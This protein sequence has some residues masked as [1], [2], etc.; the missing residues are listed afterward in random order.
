MKITTILG[1]AYAILVC[2]PEGSL[3]FSP[4]NSAAIPR[5]RHSHSLLS[6]QLPLA[7]TADD[8]EHAAQPGQDNEDPLEDMDQ[9]RKENLFQ[10]L[11]RDL[12]IEGVPLLECD[13]FQ[14]H[15]LQAALWTTMAELS[16]QNDEQKVCLVLQG[17][18]VEALMT[19]VDDFLILKTQSRL[20][21]ALPE[22]E[23]FT[24]NVVGKG[25]GPA[26]VIETANK[27]KTS[28]TNNAVS[29]EEPK[30]N[31]AMKSFIDRVVAGQ[32]VCPYTKSAAKAPEGLE[33]VNI[34]A[35]PIGYRYSSFSD[36]CH[37]LSGFWNCVCELLSV[38]ADNLSTVVY[39]MPALGSGEESDRAAHDRFSAVA[40]LASRS[41]C[42]FRGDDV[43]DILHFYP[44]YERDL[45]FPND[46]PAYGHLPPR[47]WLRPMMRHAGHAEEAETLSDEDIKIINFQRRS[48]FPAIVI[49]RVAYFEALAGSEN[50]IV[51]LQ[52]EDGSVTKASGVPVYAKNAIKLAA[53][54]Q[55]KLQEAL[56]TEIANGQ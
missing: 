4:A 20:M 5:A 3:A 33:A 22:L 47:G 35:G 28:D 37:I 18:G 45:I 43:F 41:L 50:E 17:I 55:E 34:Q 52:L 7:A 31:A 24:I 49:K 8:D 19:F 27:T 29:Y 39:T 54:G 48:P 14:A 36:V 15:T 13:A 1:H 56:Q 32:N 9:S 25:L 16:D 26:I 51:D 21:E 53:E 12:Q 30:V 2:L 38:P 40:E 10:C 42:L 46:Q 11:L 23:R 6:W 44:T